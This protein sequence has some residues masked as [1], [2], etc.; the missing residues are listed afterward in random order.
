MNASAVHGA[1]HEYSAA[2]LVAPVRVLHGLLSL[3]ALM[4]LA[5]LTAMLFRPPDL[6]SFPFDRAVFLALLGCVGFRLCLGRGR[7]RSYPATWPLLALMLLGLWGVLTQPYDPQAW[8]LLAEKWIVPFVLFH[9]AGTVFRDLSSLRKLETFSLIVFAYLTAISVFYL[10]DAKFLIFPRFI[11]DEGIGIHADRARG[12]FLQAVANGVCLNILGLIALDSFHRKRLRGLLAGVLF[13]AGPL[14]LL[15]TKTRAVW[16]STAISIGFLAF[17]GF[18]RRVRRVALALCAVVALGFGAALLYRINSSSMADRLEDRSPVDFRVVM[19]QTGWQMFTE[20]P[21]TGW[22]GQNL[23]P[24]I[25][26]RVWDFHPEYYV[27]H[28][29]YLELAVERGLIGLGLYAWLMLCLFR[30]SRTRQASADGEPHF[31]DS[32]FR[33]LWP[34][35]LGVYLLNASAV[36][37]NYQFV[38]GFLFTIAG[39]LS[40][41]NAAQPRPVGVLRRLERER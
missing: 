15:A 23:Q 14:A 6:K 13:L 27:F 41:Q 1:R 5:A 8:S 37:M 34:L 16:L 17:F 30:L 31:L 24:E 11:L 7:L 2:L 9:L 10:A 35:L 40:A 26:Q 36:V 28:N 18:D 4:F 19:Y 20:K 3:P 38:N 29:T 25:A 22:G 32:N 39:I 21:L 12:P 33:K